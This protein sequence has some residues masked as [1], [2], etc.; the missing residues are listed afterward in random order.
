MLD[1]VARFDYFSFTGL[2]LTAGHG[3]NSEWV[4]SV[5]LGTHATDVMQGN[6]AESVSAAK[7]CT[8]IGTLLSNASLVAGTLAVHETFWPT[9][10]RRAYKFRHTGAGGFI[11]W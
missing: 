4:S 7:S 8:G 6:L 3:T 10:G 9:I 2:L 11:V 5:S 1:K